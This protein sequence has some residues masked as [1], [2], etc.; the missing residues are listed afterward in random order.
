M[1]I[2]SIANQKGG[3]GKTT[4]AVTLC[5]LLAKQEVRVLLIDLDPQGSLTRYLRVDPDGVSEPNIRTLFTQTLPTDRDAL[6]RMI[7][8]TKFKHISLI[9]AH[10]SMM[11]IDKMM[12]QR[13]GM[14]WILARALTQLEHDFDYVILDCSPVAGTLMVNALAAAQ[15]LIIPVQTAYLALHGLE[16]MLT[17]V[18]MIEHSL[19]RTVQKCIVPT[20]FNA[21]ARVHHI[22]YQK[23]QHMWGNMV[24]SHPIPEDIRFVE[25]SFL[26]VLPS[27]LMKSEG[28]NAYRLLLNSLLTRTAT[29]RRSDVSHARN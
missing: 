19:Q 4:T 9:P 6:L 22:A 5:G 26:G 18:K 25:A 17:T 7:H 1:E 28:V 23:I 2:W 21:H 27:S 12:G 16:C 20:L 29:V 8:E 14:G 13:H 10:L 24:V 15:L 3:V 11:S